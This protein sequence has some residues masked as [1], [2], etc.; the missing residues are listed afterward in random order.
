MLSNITW[1]QFFSFILFFLSAY[2]FAI[3]LFFYR[4]DILS[5]AVH[6]VRINGN[7]SEELQATTVTG[8]TETGNNEKIDKKDGIREP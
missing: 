5:W 2:Y 1:Q 7:E 6:G 3:I 8:L 4:K